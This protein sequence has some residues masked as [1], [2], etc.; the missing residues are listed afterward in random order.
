VLNGNH[1]LDLYEKITIEKG[2]SIGPGVIIMTHNSYDT[3]CFLNESLANQ[4]GT[5]A[6]C[7]KA[8]ASIKANALITHGVTIGENSVVAGSA[9]VNRDVEPCHFVA[10]IPAATKKLIAQQKA[11]SF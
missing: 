4:V 10:G 9:V 2:V 8:G 11:R 1:F 7:I 6:V 3:N 5:K